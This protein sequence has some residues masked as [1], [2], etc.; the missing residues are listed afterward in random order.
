MSES[1]IDPGSLEGDALTQW[2]LRSPADIERERQEASARRYQDFFY[3]A[4]GNDPDPEFG[5][6][7]PSSQDIDP[8]LAI[9]SPSSP[10][11]ID[12]G[13]TWVPPGP[14]RFRSVRVATDRPPTA[15]SFGGGA[16][17]TDAVR[18]DVSYRSPEGIPP[19]GSRSRQLSGSPNASPLPAD[20]RQIAAHRAVGGPAYLTPAT[21]PLPTFFSS[22]FGGPVPLTSPEGHV[23]GYYD[24]QAAKAGLGITAQYAQIAPWLQPAG[25]MDGLIAAGGGSRI[26]LSGVAPAVRAVESGLKTPLNFLEREAWQGRSAVEQAARGLSD[27]A[28]AALRRQARDRFAQASGISASEIGAKVHH[29]KPLEYAHLE[30]AADPNRLANLWGLPDEAHQIASNEWTA[31]RAALKGRIPSQAEIMAAK[32]RI[33]RMVEPYLLRAGLS[34]PG[35]TPK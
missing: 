30:P 19:V 32:L 21:L 3:G 7:V 16:P 26:A 14:N 25:W 33:D 29:S 1:W 4:P 31:F 8:G 5:R 23:V 2:Y 20:A 35:P 24:H 13:F 6:E 15:T 9:S 22:L 27:A 28:K 12:P 34:R 10:K 18:S 11:D 17:P